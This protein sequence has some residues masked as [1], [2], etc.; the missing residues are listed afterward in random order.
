MLLLLMVL[1]VLML[2]P[3]WCGML[4]LCTRNLACT[5]SVNALRTLSHTYR[6]VYITLNFFG[7][8]AHAHQT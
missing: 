5:A 6:C 4:Q 3:T 2:Q 8:P 1:M 7:F